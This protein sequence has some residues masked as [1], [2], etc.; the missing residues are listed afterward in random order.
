MDDVYAIYTKENQLK[1]LGFKDA[2]I[3]KYKIKDLGELSWFL[4]I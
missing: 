3:K 2:I 1:F 4:G